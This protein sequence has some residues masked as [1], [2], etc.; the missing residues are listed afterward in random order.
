M[1]IKLGLMLIAAGA[2]AL[3]IYLG[4][5]HYTGLVAD[6][7]TARINQS[8]LETAVETQKLTIDT[9]ASAITEWEAHSKQM[10]ATM[11][12]L[13]EAQQ[14]ATV[15]QRKLANVFAKHDLKKL[16]AAKPALVERAIN[17]G[18]ADVFSMFRN[19]T[20]RGGVRPGAGAASPGGSDASPGASASGPPTD[21]VE[22]PDTANPA[23]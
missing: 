15:Y 1:W 4:Y 11:G 14:E 12:A 10:Q 5:N 9:M 13:A 3:I 19:E 16:S 7:E 21:P 20:T 8:K 23:P 22:G 2:V 6:L 17:R 18:T